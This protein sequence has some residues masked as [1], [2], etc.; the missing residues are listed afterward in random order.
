MSKAENVNGIRKSTL[1]RIERAERNYK[2]AFFSAALIET[3]FLV[4]FLLLADLSNRLHLLLL[5]GTVATYSILLLSLVALG[6]QLNRNTLRLLKAI[7]MLDS[8]LA[9]GKR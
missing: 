9:A 3:F 6:V 8:H 1:D 7:E 2:V 5:L 4:G